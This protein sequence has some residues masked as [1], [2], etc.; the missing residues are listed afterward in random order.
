[1][2]AVLM[3]DCAGL[4]QRTLLIEADGSRNVG[5]EVVWLQGITAY[6]DSRGFAGRLD[7]HEDV[8]EW[9]RDIDIEP[10]GP[11][12]DAGRMHWE[13]HT[14]IEAGV[15]ADYVEHWVRLDGPVPPCWGL[16]LRCDSDAAILLRVGG[17]FGWADR[18]GV[19]VGGVGGDDWTALSPRL[20]GSDLEANGV[21][22]CVEDSEGN[23]DL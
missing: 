4:W 1:M 7:Q 22:W 21:R 12:P 16:F 10:P 9:N 6:V 18:G 3:A 2:T 15:H 23:V 8:F 19:R 5:T 20:R 11:F 14:L 13:D 17:T